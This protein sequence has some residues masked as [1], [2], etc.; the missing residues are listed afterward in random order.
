MHFTFF[1]IF[2][3]TSNISKA[4]LSKWSTD[5]NHALGMSVATTSYGAGLVIG[6]ALSG[7]LA[8]PLNQYNI[9]VTSKST[10]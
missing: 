3:A 6:P 1:C 4:F 8:D 5:Y 7:F 9:T 10:C 2:L